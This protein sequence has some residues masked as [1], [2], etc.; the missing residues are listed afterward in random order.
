[1]V[2]LHQHRA[3]RSA[4]PGAAVAGHV[5]LVLGVLFALAV[6]YAY[7]LSIGDGI[8]PPDWARVAG[9]LWLPV[10]LAG[11]PVGYY[12]ARGGPREPR[13]ELGLV[14]ALAAALAFVVLVVILG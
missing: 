12:W 14:L 2:T 7:A 9:L 8:D 6:A 3:R 4:L 1:M 5:T 11:V 10:G 13:A